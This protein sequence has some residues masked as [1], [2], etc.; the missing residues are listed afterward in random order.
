L[1]PNYQAL[2]A[3]EWLKDLSKPE[4]ITEEDEE[5]EENDASSEAVA[6]AAEKVD[7]SHS[8][9]A[10]PEVA[11]WVKEVLEK[12]ANGQYGE[13]AGKPALHAAPLDAVASPLTSPNGAR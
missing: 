10:D 7:I 6:G 1:R 4:T 2:L 5:A 3:S 12:K 11:E 8:G 13:T 9:T